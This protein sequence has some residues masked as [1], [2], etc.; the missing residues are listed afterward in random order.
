MTGSFRNRLA[1]LSALLSGLALLVFCLCTWSLIRAQ[2]LNKLDREIQSHAEREVSRVRDAQGWQRTLQDMAN[3]LDLGEPAA[4]QQIYLLVQD[5][6]GQSLFVSANWPASLTAS[7]NWPTPQPPD[8]RSPQP[9]PDGARLARPDRAWEHAPLAVA[10]LEPGVQERPVVTHL[11]QDIGQHTLRIGLAT[12]TRGRIAVA[13][14]Q[15]IVARELAE[16]RNMFFIALPMALVLIA[17]GSWVFSGRALRPVLTLTQ[18]VQQI[19]AKG[20]NT[21]LADTGTEREFS[22]LI[23]VFNE[24][25]ERLERSFLQTRRFSADAAHELKTPLAILQGQLERA[26]QD[27]K[28]GSS[29][30]RALTEILDEVRRLSAISAKLLMLSQADA[31]HLPIQP[32]EVD[33]SSLLEELLED[34]Q[35]LAPQLTL[36]ADI[37]PGIRLCCDRGLLLQV[38]HNLVSNAIKYNLNPGWIELYVSHSPSRVD[39]C[40]RNPSADLDPEQSDHLFERFYRTDTARSRKVD[41]VG[42]GLSLSREIIRAHGGEMSLQVTAEG[43]VNLCFWLPDSRQK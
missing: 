10:P 17:L 36:R 13:A 20:L 28:T 30:Q 42:L 31:G 24:M 26:I 23:Q 8:H 27:A 33:L 22:E 43:V 11:T 12:T 39:I 2:Q 5:D 16:I 9:R 6:K 3:S 38:L 4:M 37:P 32:E 1:L 29:L 25:L 18:T 40:L 14:D 19:S 7:L 41:G 35:L 21:R 34:I 15:R